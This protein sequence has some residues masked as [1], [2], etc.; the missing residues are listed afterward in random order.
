MSSTPTLTAAEILS[1]LAEQKQTMSGAYGLREIGLFGSYADGQAVSES[2]IDLLVD[3]EDGHKSL[4]NFLRLK[5]ELEKLLGREVDL[6][7]KSALKP[8]LR[9]RILRQVRYV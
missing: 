2:D 4:F 1:L 3:L 6:V 7:M 9:E 5:F 8:R